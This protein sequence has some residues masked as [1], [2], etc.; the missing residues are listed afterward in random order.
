M[1]GIFKIEIKLG[2]DAMQQHADVANALLDVAVKLYKGHVSGGIIDTN[3][4]TVG[5]FWME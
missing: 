4:N 2:N 3:G 1:Y 5:K